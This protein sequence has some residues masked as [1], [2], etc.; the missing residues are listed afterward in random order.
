MDPALAICAFTR[1]AALLRRHFADRIHE[2]DSLA[3]AALTLLAGKPGAADNNN[4][5]RNDS[6]IKNRVYC[7]KCGEEHIAMDSSDSE[8]LQELRDW[9]KRLIE[10]FQDLDPTD[11]IVNGERNVPTDRSADLSGACAET[12]GK[13]TRVRHVS[14]FLR[15]S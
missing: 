7:A 14:T 3:E 4:H 2:R 5:N 13:I 15:C 10:E 1:K 6:I 11:V 12:V 8:A 9:Q